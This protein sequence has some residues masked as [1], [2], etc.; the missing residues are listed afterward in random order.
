MCNEAS[1]EGGTRSSSE[2]AWA[3]TYT[4]QEVQAVQA[5]ILCEGKDAHKEGKGPTH[6]T[7]P[8]FRIN[9]ITA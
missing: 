2:R 5:P 9:A 3:R 6:R 7:H 1:S 4:L 8:D